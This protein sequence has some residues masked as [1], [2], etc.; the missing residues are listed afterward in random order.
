MGREIRPWVV[1]I[2]MKESWFSASLGDDCRGF[3]NLTFI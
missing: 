1:R 3:Q 2:D